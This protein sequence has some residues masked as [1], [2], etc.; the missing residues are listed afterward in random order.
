MMMKSF[1]IA[2]TGLFA[3]ALLW[4]MASLDLPAVALELPE[5]LQNLIDKAASDLNFP[6]PF[7]ADAEVEEESEE[8]AQALAEYPAALRAP[9]I[10][11]PIPDLEAQ[12]A[13]SVPQRLD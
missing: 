7:S 10:Q 2:L 8:P 4:L 9:E 11:A 3:A 1:W 5:D 13:A 6:F 12:R